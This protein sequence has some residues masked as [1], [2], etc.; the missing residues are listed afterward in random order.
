MSITIVEPTFASYA[1]A[2]AWLGS[3][4]NVISAYIIQQPGTLQYVGY[5]I[6]SS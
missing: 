5:A 1:L 2:L 3:L 4:Q 6:L